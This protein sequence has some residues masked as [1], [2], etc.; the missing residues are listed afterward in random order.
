[1]QIP[2]NAIIS[3]PRSKE[4]LTCN[5]SFLSAKTPRDPLYCTREMLTLSFTYLQVPPDFVDFLSLFGRQSRP[6]HFHFSAFR[7]RIRLC[8]AI[9]PVRNYTPGLKIESIG[10][11]GRD[12]SVCYNLKSVESSPWQW[13]WSIEDCAV[14]HSFD[15]EFSRSTWI[16]IKGD[17]N[18]KDRIMLA[19]KSNRPSG[20]TSLQPLDRAFAATLLNHLLLCDWA[21]EGWSCYTIFL[22]EKYHK[23]SKK[24]V[25]NKLELPLV[26][27][28]EGGGTVSQLKGSEA[29][30]GT[31][32]VKTAFSR[33]RTRT[34][35]ALRSIKK[36]P[37]TPNPHQDADL[38]AGQ[39]QRFPPGVRKLAIE[40]ETSGQESF[41]PDD[42]QHLQHIQDKA[43]EAV[44]V[45]KLNLSVMAQMRQCY[46]KATSSP[47]F[48]SYITTS[49]AQDL[50]TFDSAVKGYE[51]A[52]RM[53]VMRLDT[54]IGYIRECKTLVRNH[55]WKL[56]PSLIHIQLQAVLDWQ[57]KEINKY[58][59]CQSNVSMMNMERMAW[60]MNDLARKTKT[61]TVSMK[62]IT[63]VTLAFLPG[64]YISV[65][66]HFLPFSSLSLRSHQI[67]SMQSYFLH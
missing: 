13:P 6:K 24:A 38:E 40:F 25:S 63:L 62:V 48:P 53:S 58:L 65:S 16:I 36:K 8:S 32:S 21:V 11:S 35:G 33:A 56:E 7:K 9:S 52:I 61:E 59:A 28:P 15:L 46:R 42:L 60:E 14:S 12:I 47:D 23:I 64:T 39:D 57:N 17:N 18:I 66:Y 37:F 4:E 54:L 20:L 5:F 31:K 3:I 2:V 49:C 43:S 51:D 44:L 27:R 10:W 29:G 55:N 19:A 45:L 30:L 1:M 50:G 22:E 34:F 67:G 41:S 26:V